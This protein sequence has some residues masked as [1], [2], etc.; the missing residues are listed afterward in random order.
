MVTPNIGSTFPRHVFVRAANLQPS[1]HDRVGDRQDCFEA[2]L[3]H[4]TER[5]S[6]K[7]IY[8]IGTMNKSTML[9]QRTQRLIEEVKPDAVYV[10]T[11]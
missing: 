8:L 1:V 10:Q 3:I 4:L 2:T 5:F 7:E 9:A 11:N 6:G